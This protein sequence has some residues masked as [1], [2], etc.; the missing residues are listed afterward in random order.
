MCISELASLANASCKAEVTLKVPFHEVVQVREV[1][2]NVMS[3]GTQLDL[4]PKYLCV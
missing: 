1:V 2:A 3:I 4:Q